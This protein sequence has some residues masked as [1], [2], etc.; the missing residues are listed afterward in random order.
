MPKIY[1][2]DLEYFLELELVPVCIPT[3]FTK[4]CTLK[5]V[6]SQYLQP[7][8]TP[9]ADSFYSKLYMYVPAAIIYNQKESLCENTVWL[10]SYVHLTRYYA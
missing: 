4:S 5:F 2:K 1:I 9:S 6:N 3:R 7:S 10:L 8:Q